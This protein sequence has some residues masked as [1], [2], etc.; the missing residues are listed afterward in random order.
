LTLHQH[1]DRLA[2]LKPAG[3]DGVR[4]LPYFLGE[5]TPIHDPNARGL[6][7]GL[8]LSHD[9]GHVWRALLEAYAYAIAHHVEALNDIGH[10]TE[11][12]LVSDGGSNSRIWMQIVADVLQKPVQRLTGHPGSCLGAA[13]TAAVGVGATD[14]WSGVA[15]FVGYGDRLDPNPGNAEVYAAG[16]LEFRDLYRPSAP[17]SA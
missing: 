4:V 9:I 13:W 14:D 1:L 5:K 15:R 8:T 7:G 3:A 12:Y 16:Y 6:I 10:R 2:E 17:R 11:K